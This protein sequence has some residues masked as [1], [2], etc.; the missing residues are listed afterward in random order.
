MLDTFCLVVLHVDEV[1]QLKLKS[2]ERFL[3]RRQEAAAV[4]AD[5]GAAAVTWV[6]EPIN[7]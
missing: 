4:P 2:N 7:P 3:Y 1:E 5:E 6:E